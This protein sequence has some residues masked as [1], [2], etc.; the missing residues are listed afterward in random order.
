MGDTTVKKIDSKQ[1]PQGKEGQKY[2]ATGK[3]ISMRLWQ[4]E[5]DD[6]A[7]PASKRAY[8]T[9]GYVIKGSAELHI[10]GQMVKLNKATAGL[11]QKMQS[12]TTKYC[13]HL[14][15][16]K[17]PIHQLKYMTETRQSA[18]KT[19]LVQMTKAQ[20]LTKPA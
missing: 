10:E 12:I 13:S 3:S 15:Q 2:L 14:L 4:E 6:K 7:K 5:P 9:V 19:R 1:S 20:Q 18:Q 11:C 17:R 8:E 16:L